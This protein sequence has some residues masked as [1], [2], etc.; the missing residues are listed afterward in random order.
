MGRQLFGARE[1][2]LWHAAK[3][4]D[5]AQ[6]K[7]LLLKD[8]T[9]PELNRCHASKGTTPLMAA[10][11]NKKRRAGDRTGLVVQYLIEFGADVNVVDRTDHKTTALHYAAYAN[12]SIATE[13]LLHAGAN[14][15]ALNQRGHTPLDV[16]RLRGRKQAAGVLTHHLSIKSGWLDL[17]TSSLLPIW[18]HRWCVLL[19][20]NADR[21]RYE[22]C[23]FHDPS[24]A[25]PEH[26]MHIDP[27]SRAELVAGST[28][29][30][31]SWLD[32]PYMFTLD[33][34]LVHQ[35]VSGRRFSRDLATGLT[36]GH[37]TVQVKNVQFAAESE[38][39]RYAWMAQL[40]NGAHLAPTPTVFASAPLASSFVH[41]SS[42]GNGDAPLSPLRPHLAPSAPAR[43]SSNFDLFTA[44]FSRPSYSASSSTASFSPPPRT[45]LE[46]P[47]TIVP[48]FS[49]LSV[50]PPATDAMGMP[51]SAPSFRSSE[52]AY[53]RGPGSHVNT[54][55]ASYTASTVGAAV[56]APSTQ[57]VGL[58]GATASTVSAAAGAQQQQ[59]PAA[60]GAK[61]GGSGQ[62]CVIC[63]DA[64]RDAICVPCGH[65]AGCH[66]CLS[67]I[68]RQ[69]MSQA[70]CPIC[71]AL[72]HSVVKIYDC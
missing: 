66:A 29:R 37:G 13:Y 38:Q 39:S 45:H 35:G 41:T 48:A 11:R 49:D 6:V 55:D 10:C 69:S 47:T 16:A 14:A 4:L 28:S 67:A 65:I 71:R 26:V 1:D 5:D 9:T 52:S 60:P 50:A 58:G 12:A 23:V 21:T 62:D 36:H 24:D 43:R 34:P 19:A 33:R 61:I 7:A 17:A 27:A 42:S 68:K 54:L 3:K 44:P 46:S 53:Y 2:A 8:P 72:V 63:M 20:C 22:L 15:F 70:V 57:A 31:A 40:G 30:V 51:P 56:A 18:K 64:V 59:T 32:K 25:V